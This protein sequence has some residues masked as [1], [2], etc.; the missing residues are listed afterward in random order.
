MI[1]CLITYY[2]SS[3]DRVIHFEKTGKF[4]S[5]PFIG[6]HLSLRAEHLSLRAE[7]LHVEDVIFCEKEP[8]ILVIT[9]KKFAD[10]EAQD[11]IDD[12]RAFGWDVADDS[13]IGSKRT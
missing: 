4:Q 12:M 10:S 13:T 2:F 3:E 1:E 11:I 8:P 5:V 9:T 6:S 7:H